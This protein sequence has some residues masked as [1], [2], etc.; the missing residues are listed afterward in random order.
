MSGGTRAAS[1]DI[2]KAFDRFWQVTIL[3]LPKSYRISGRVFDLISVFLSYKRLRVVLDRMSF[4]EFPVITGVPQG[5]AFGPSLFLLY[6][7]D[8]SDDA[9]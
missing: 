7:N 5:S 1:L 9:K 4:Q 8:L 3:H 6:I 2:S